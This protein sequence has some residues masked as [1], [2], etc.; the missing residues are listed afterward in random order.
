MTGSR[1]QNMWS[2]AD[3]V[4]PAD[5]LDDF[6]VWA[7]GEGASDVSF[8]TG[9]PAMIEKDGRLLRA[10]RA[11][12]D[13]VVLSLL[14]DRVHGGSA[15]AVLRS[16]RAIDC[17]H[18]AGTA[19]G[20]QLRFRC[21][22]SAILVAGGFGINMT[23]RVLPDR[24]PR[25]AELSIEPEIASAW[26]AGDGSA[27]GGLTLVTGVPGS[28]KSTL[29]AAGTRHLLETG[30][31]PINASHLIPFPGWFPSRVI[32]PVFLLLPGVRSRIGSGSDFLPRV[33]VCRARVVVS[34]DG[35]LP[36]RRSG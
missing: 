9:A 17:S 12:L 13:G 24:V 22:V 33:S 19:R 28:G 10:S 34:M 14:A 27:L 5:R 20:R 29:L 31:G 15:E 25:L 8:Q 6:L 1:E 35:S 18:A 11:I 4:F 3:H 21:N 16:G 2:G 7:V 36:A 32:G 30:A 23:L 26:D